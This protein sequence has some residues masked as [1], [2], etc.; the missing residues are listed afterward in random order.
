MNTSLSL[1]NPQVYEKPILIIGYGSTEQEDVG[2]G[3]LVA[4]AIQNWRIENVKAL[5]VDILSPSL[6]PLIIKAKTVIFVGSY[7]LYEHMKPELIIKH[8]LPN[9]SESNSKIIYDNPPQTLLGFINAVYHK[10]PEAYWILI[11]AL[12]HELSSHLSHTTQR[13]IAQ[14]L[15]YLRLNLDTSVSSSWDQQNQRKFYHHQWRQLKLIN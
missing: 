4:K 8:F 11:P 5:S 14:S 10:I 15:K 6:A 3:Y 13:A 1:T 12:N 7:N 9:H 2:A